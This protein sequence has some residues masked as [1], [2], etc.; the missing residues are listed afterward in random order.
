MLDVHHSR[1]WGRYGCSD[2]HFVRYAKD[3]GRAKYNLLASA[4]SSFRNVEGVFI[5]ENAIPL[6][7]AQF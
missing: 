1:I 7:I 4:T 5:L 2:G 3:W 6:T